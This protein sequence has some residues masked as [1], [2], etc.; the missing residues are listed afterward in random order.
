MKVS[1]YCLFDREANLREY[2]T[3]DKVVKR[4]SDKS[5]AM[6]KSQLS[7]GC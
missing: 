5:L 4:V 1:A 3:H 7:R 6:G 2:S